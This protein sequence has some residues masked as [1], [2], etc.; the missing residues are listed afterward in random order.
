MGARPS[1]AEH[2]CSKAAGDWTAVSL[3]V[4]LGTPSCTAINGVTQLQDCN[5]CSNNTKISLDDKAI[6]RQF[7]FIFYKKRLL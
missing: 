4:P 7:F 3:A 5:F 2:C 6:G 1:V